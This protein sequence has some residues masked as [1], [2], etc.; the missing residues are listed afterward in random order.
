V[1]SGSYQLD[2]EAKGFRKYSSRNNQ[3]NIGQPTTLNVKLEVGAVVD[4]V[5]VQASSEAV[6]TSNS[7]NY[8][9]LISSTAI[10]DLPVV[11]SRGRNP[12]DL[13]I[14]QPGVVSGA[15]T[16][17]GI[18]VHGARDR[19]W[20]Y[21]LDGID[22]NDSSQ[23][24]SNTT[25]FRL[26]PDMLE[27]MRVLTGNN[28]AENGRNSGGQVAMVTRS[29]T[30]SFHGDGFWFYRTP[31]LNANEWEN[32]I[33]NLGKAQLQ[34]KIYGGS[35]SGPVIKNKTFFFVQ[36]QALR[37]RSSRGVT[38]TVYTATARTWRAAL[39]QRRAQPTGRNRDGFGGCQRQSAA[40]L[41]IGTV[42][43]RAERSGAQGPRSDGYGGTQEHAAAQPLHLGRR[44]QHRGLRFQRTGLR[45]PARS[46]HQDRSVRQRQE[47]RLRPRCLGS[48][49]QPLRRGQRRSADLPGRTLPGEHAARTAQL[50]RQL[51][52][53]AD[54]PDD[55]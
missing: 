9:N 38:R 41:N 53:H 42:Q 17:A 12:L 31:R 34:Q 22:V 2:V 37:A 40:R 29:G 10:K 21:T 35:F 11:G 27:E 48:R 5:E 45:A 39:R 32:N 36:I 46:D 25:S 50:C 3:V 6:Q 14:T 49:R 33:D 28:T 4:T 47:H 1:Q 54:Q 52:L 15:P 8:G 26:N 7:G 44:T 20:N 18:H 43:H 13:V 51:A 19:S 16:A 23:G 24:G 55:Q 30:N